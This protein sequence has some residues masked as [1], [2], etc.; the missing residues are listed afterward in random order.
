M[1]FV[2]KVIL[3]L[4][5]AIE[6]AGKSRHEQLS[7]KIS[8]CSSD[9]K[10]P[11]WFTCNSQNH[12]QCGNRHSGAIACN[13][14]AQNSAILVCHCVTYSP[15]S[16]LTFAGSYFYNCNFHH[17]KGGGN[18]L[19]NQLPKQPEV[20]INNSVCAP[21]HRTGL[22]CGDCEDEYSPQV[23]SYNLS[24]VKCP[25][26]HK[27]W[28]KYGLAAFVP[29]TFFYMFIVIFSINVTSSHLHGV[30]WFSQI[31]SMPAFVRIVLHVFDINN[32][33]G[34][35]ITTKVFF[36]FFSFWNI[37]FFRSFLPSICLNVST[38]Q[39]LALDYSVALYPFVLI[40]LSYFIIELYDRKCIIIV[41]AWK[42]FKKIVLFYRT[43]WDI[44]TSIIDSFTTF[45]LLS[46]V[47][48]LSVS[49]DLLIP[50]ITYQL[51]SNKS[52]L[53]LYYS[54]TVV[55]FGDDHR[56]YAILAITILTLFVAIPTVILVLYPCHFF[57]K[58][59]SLIPLNWHFLH[60]FVDSFQGCYKDE[61]VP[62]IFD[63]R[64]F[65]AIILLYRLLLFIIISLSLSEMYYIYAIVALVILL[66]AVI[67]IQP[68]KTF[69]V[70]YLSTDLTFFS[71]LSLFYIVII[72]RIHVAIYN[73][74]T[75]YTFGSILATS[76]TF[77]PISYII[78]LIGSWLIS[79]K[80]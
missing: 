17:Q 67:N 12:C 46:Y 35:L 58:F 51:G 25:D 16:R 42:P 30:V 22:L 59:L 69:T 49:S 19:Y 14:E 56:P 60:A 54:P 73:N 11:T 29:L 80:K 74:T 34:Q 66:I 3:L 37:D 10:C 6:S 47:K 44:R 41:I 76:L 78:F 23:L 71:L 70:G 1:K 2:G 18:R 79:R 65:S 57:Q 21:F 55:Y 26:G 7:N 38:I 77:V 72:G 8:Q 33:S 68:F 31:I 63:C 61:T 13:N 20:L 52:K 15:K 24:C 75:F 5:L 43:S 45:F 40:L 50:T 62:G 48:I 64:W 9:S 4:A 32:N 28:W 39:A 36:A 27:N 53:G